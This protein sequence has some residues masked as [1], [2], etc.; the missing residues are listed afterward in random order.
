[1]SDIP[2]ET[3][4]TVE[5]DLDRLTEKSDRLPGWYDDVFDGD[6]NLAEPSSVLDDLFLSPSGPT[7]SAASVEE[8]D[9]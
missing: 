8:P 9:I 6:G 2:N 7:I 5:T 3:D 4:I 1:M